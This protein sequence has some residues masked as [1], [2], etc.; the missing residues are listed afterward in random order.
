M[1]SPV[2]KAFYERGSSRGLPELSVLEFGLKRPLDPSFPILLDPHDLFGLQ[3]LL[4]WG[5]MNE[6]AFASALAGR[7]HPALLEHLHPEQIAARGP[8]D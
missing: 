2:F 8:I 5:R 4:W 6:F 3:Q 1:E 7:N